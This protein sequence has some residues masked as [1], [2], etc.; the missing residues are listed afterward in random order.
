LQPGGGGGGGS[1]GQ[2]AGRSIKSSGRRRTGREVMTAMPP[3]RSMAAQPAMIRPKPD[4][5][6]CQPA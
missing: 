2:L 1:V 4:S 5:S 3:G 6:P